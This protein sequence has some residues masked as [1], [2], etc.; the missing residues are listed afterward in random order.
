M[1]QENNL[2]Y[3]RIL[4]HVK[5]EKIFPVYLFFGNENYLKDNILNKFKN[6]L[7]D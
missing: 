3:E 7:I 4:D 1:K 2:S 6:K 5:K